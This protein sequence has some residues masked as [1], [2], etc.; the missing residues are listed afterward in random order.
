MLAAVAQWE[1]RMIG[2]RTSEALQVNIAGGWTSPSWDVRVPRAVRRRIV[3][4]AAAGMSQRGI[5]ERLNA[6]VFRR[7]V[8]GGTAAQSSVCCAS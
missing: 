4:M 8:A 7:S 3:K 5:A 1:R 6:T 2:V